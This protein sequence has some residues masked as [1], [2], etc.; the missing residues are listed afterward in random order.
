ML[1]G[2]LQERSSRFATQAAIGQPL[3]LDVFVAIPNG[4]VS[5]LTGTVQIQNVLQA[6]LDAGFPGLGGL[7]ESDGR[8]SRHRY[9]DGNPQSEHTHFIPQLET[10]IRLSAY[11]LSLASFTLCSKRDY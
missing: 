1:K 11:G 7:G 10:P 8:R 2:W 4:G 3:A 6:R 5:I 9:G